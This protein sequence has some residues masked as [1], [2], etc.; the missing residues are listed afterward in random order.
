MWLSANLLRNTSIN[1]CLEI[2]LDGYGFRPYG[3]PG[4]KLFSLFNQNTK[5]KSLPIRLLPF[6]QSPNIQAKINCK[7]GRKKVI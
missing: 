5:I 3:Y 7:P 2:K 6:P 1:F 4:S